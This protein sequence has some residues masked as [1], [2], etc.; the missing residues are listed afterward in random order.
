M[1]GVIDLRSGNVMKINIETN[2]GSVT[3]KYEPANKNDYRE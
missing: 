1:V 3:M 2:P